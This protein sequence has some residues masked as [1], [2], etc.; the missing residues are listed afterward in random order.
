MLTSEEV[1][2][3]WARVAAHADELRPNFGQHDLLLLTV[4]NREGPL[5]DVV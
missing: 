1:L 5:E 3:V 4:N 2:A